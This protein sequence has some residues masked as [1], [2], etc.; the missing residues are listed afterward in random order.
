MFTLV[1]LCFFFQVLSGYVL[2]TQLL[3]IGVTLLAIW[4]LFMLILV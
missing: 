1:P 3:S 2:E 4:I